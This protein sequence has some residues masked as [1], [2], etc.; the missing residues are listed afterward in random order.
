MGG[1][2]ATGRRVD[3]PSVINSSFSVLFV[4]LS[5]SDSLTVPCFLKC[6]L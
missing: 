1:G 5:F 2:V 3:V 6:D 4:F